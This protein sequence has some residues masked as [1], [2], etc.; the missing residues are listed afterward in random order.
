MSACRG[1]DRHYNLKPPYVN[2]ASP[3]AF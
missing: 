1:R 2:P 3:G